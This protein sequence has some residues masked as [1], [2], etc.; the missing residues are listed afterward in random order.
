MKFV[1]D[2]GIHQSDAMDHSWRSASGSE[3]PSVQK[4]VRTISL[5]VLSATGFRNPGKSYPFHSSSDSTVQSDDETGYRKTLS[6]VLDNAV[7]IML[8]PYRY[9]KGPFVPK[10]LVEVGDASRAFKSHLTEM[11]EHETD[12]LK[13]RKPISVGIMSGFVHSLETHRKELK[14]SKDGNKGQEV[15]EILSSLFVINFAG[16]DTTA[17]TLTYNLYLLS[18]YPEVQA[19]LGEDIS[20]VTQDAPVEEWEYQELFPRLPRCREILL[21]T[22][23]VYAPI[24][25]LSK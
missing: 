14:T 8:I 21:E 5:N 13:E 11:L 17:N 25:M 12:A 20:A 6:T 9:L 10:K 23:R 15:D 1:W 7:L 19:W 16:H 22:L 18:V 24:M 3:I 2:E 4:D